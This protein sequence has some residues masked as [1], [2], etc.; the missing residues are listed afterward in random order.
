MTHVLSEAE[1]VPTPQTVRE[2]G[3]DPIR[4]VLCEEA[5]AAH[6]VTRETAGHS[7][8]VGLPAGLSQVAVYHQE[9][10]SQAAA[11]HQEGL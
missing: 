6:L 11:Y 5:E 4:R 10:P 7:V 9:G 3:D 2:A 1:A 8:G